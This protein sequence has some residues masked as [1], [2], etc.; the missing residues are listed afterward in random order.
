MDHPYADLIGLHVEEQ[1]AGYS[2]CTLEVAHKHCNPHGVAHGAVLYALADTGMDAALYPTL[3]PTQICA[4]VQITMNYF[5]PV[6]SGVITCTTE[7]VNRGK[8]IA[9]L[10]SRITV[11]EALVATA[12]GNYS[13]F[14]PNKIAT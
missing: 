1:R 12:S 11:A 10:E 6:V 2:K 9:Y 8:N 3:N 7:V 5:K 4:T 14:S 13:I